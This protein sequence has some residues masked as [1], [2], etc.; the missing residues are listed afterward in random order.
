MRTILKNYN[1]FF[2]FFS[3]GRVV[4]VF[5]PETISNLCVNLITKLLEFPDKTH[6]SVNFI[7]SNN[8]IDSME[9]NERT[10]GS[11]SRALQ[12]V[13]QHMSDVRW[14]EDDA[15]RKSITRLLDALE[16][17]LVNFYNFMLF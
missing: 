4:T 12:L 3:I 6:E 13:F 1:S 11:L 10:I 2:C 15:V 16:A 8:D 7:P 5:R 17:E 14:S 9:A